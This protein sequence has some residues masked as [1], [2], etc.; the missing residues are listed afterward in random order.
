M[1]HAHKIKDSANSQKTC[2]LHKR[3]KNLAADKLAHHVSDKL[4]WLERPNDGAVLVQKVHPAGGLWI[5]Q[6]HD[7]VLCVEYGLNGQGCDARHGKAKQTDA[8]GQRAEVHFVQHKHIA[9]LVAQVRC[10]VKTV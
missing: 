9:V 8:K 5:F 2:V 7:A 3:I 1:M 4:L 6:S 10:Q